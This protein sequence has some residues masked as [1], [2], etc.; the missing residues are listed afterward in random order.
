MS[1]D[2][3]KS[4]IKQEHSIHRQTGLKFKEEINEIQHLQQSFVRWH[5]N[6]R[7][8]EKQTENN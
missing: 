8:F 1:G 4:S 7:R 6:L 2:H 5:C 3:D